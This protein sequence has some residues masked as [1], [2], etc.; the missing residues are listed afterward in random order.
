MKRLEKKHPLAI[1]WFHWL[2]FPLL[3]L[4]LWSGTLISNFGVRELAPAFRKA[5]CCRR[6]R[7][8]SGLRET[9]ANQAGASSLGQSGSK[10]H[11]A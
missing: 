8:C 6:V 5:A 9:V 1:R 7:G 4:M 11:A 2:N 10:C 3:A